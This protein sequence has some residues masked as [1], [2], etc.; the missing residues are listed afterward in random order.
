MKA[1]ELNGTLTSSYVGDLMTFAEDFAGFGPAGK[2]FNI[3][4]AWTY[5]VCNRT[6]S[7]P[8]LYGRIIAELDIPQDK[9]GYEDVVSPFGC[10]DAGFT[11][12]LYRIDY[13][14]NRGERSK[15]V[16][17]FRVRGQR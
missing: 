4:D 16:R 15:C 9:L 2:T 1:H 5:Q 8:I 3:S 6:D 17:D 14:A 7:T 10:N 11:P 13:C 12:V